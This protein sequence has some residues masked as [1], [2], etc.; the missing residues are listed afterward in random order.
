[1]SKD[2]KNK[3]EFGDFQTPRLLADKVCQYLKKMGVQP[4]ILIEPTCGIG[5]FLQA[6]VENFKSLK[7]VFGFD[8]NKS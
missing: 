1:M 4:D 7:Q 3:I 2:N 5:A 8:I 6:G